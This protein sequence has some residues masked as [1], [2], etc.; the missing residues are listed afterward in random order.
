MMPSEER[1]LDI[2][3]NLATIDYKLKST[4][5]KRE[6]ILELFFMQGIRK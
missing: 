5:G 4:S 6:R 2:L 3:N 1:L